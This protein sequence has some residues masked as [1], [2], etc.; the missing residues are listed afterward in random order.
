[1]ESER[2]YDVRVRPPS[3][4]SARRLFVQVSREH[5][6]TVVRNLD[7]RPTALPPFRVAKRKKGRKREGRVTDATSILSKVTEM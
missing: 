6:M 2:T 1:M 4:P 7:G 5:D 3:L